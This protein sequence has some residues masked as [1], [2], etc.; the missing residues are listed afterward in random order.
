MIRECCEAMKLTLS[1]CNAMSAP[2]G[3]TRSMYVQHNTG[4]MRYLV[5]MNLPKAK[6]N[7]DSEFAGVRNMP[8][9]FCPFCGA[10]QESLDVQEDKESC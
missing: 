5:T 2:Q 1:R 7:D 4:K 8:V 10:K 9:K 3:I 6:K